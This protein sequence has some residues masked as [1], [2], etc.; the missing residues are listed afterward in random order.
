[1]SLSLN[2]AQMKAIYSSEP[3]LVV[4]APPGSGKTRCMCA[5][6]QEYQALHPTHSITAI[7]YTRKAAVELAERIHCSRVKTGTIHS[8]SLQQLYILGAKY[9]FAVELLEEEEMRRIMQKIAY[10]KNLKFVNI[11]QLYN[12]IVGNIK[13]LDLDENIQKKYEK[14]KALY[15]EYKQDRGLYD[16]T[17]LPQYLLDV[18]EEYDEEI[19]DID[20]LFVD[21]FQDIDEIQ[22]SVFEKVCARKKFYIGDF[23]QCQPAGTKVWLLGHKEKNIEDIQVGDEIVYYDQKGGRCGGRGISGT[24]L[25]KKVT[26]VANREFVN[27]NL[28]TITTENGLTSSYTPGHRTFI[29]INP[30]K[31]KHAVYLMCDSNYRFRV[32]KIPLYYDSPRSPNSWRNKLSAEKCEKIWL[33]KVF[34]TD[35]EARL[36]ETRIS[37]LYQIP[38]TC[39]QVGKVSWTKEDIDYIYEGLDTQTSADRCL[40]DYGLDINY[41][42]LDFS[43][44]WSASTHFAA[45]ATAEI[46][47]SNLM[48]EY[49]SCVVY[50]SSEGNHSN[51]HFETITKVKKTFITEPIQVY[52]LQVE[53]ETYIADGIATHNCIYGF[54]GAVEDV[55][56][57]LSKA[58]FKTYHLDTNYRSKQEIMDAADS[59]RDNCN[60]NQKIADMK[61]LEHSPI[62]CE[63]GN[64]GSIYIIDNNQYCLSMNGSFGSDNAR[65]IVKGLL[66]KPGTMVLCRSNKQVRK[67]QTLGIENC[68]TVHQ[69]KGL[70]YDNVILCDIFVN[71][72][73]ELNV[74]YVGMTRARDE[75]CIIDF[76]AFVGVLANTTI[77]YANNAPKNTLF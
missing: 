24:S 48:P 35:K 14:I 43:I 1:M 60:Y 50:G 62:C 70:E 34:D 38:Q 37:Y 13:T 27:D 71:N 59:F 46:Y 21:E 47:A 33:L 11:Y 44:P 30:I 12:Y 67:L 64:G 65:I 20:A 28:I 32:G 31:D 15:I 58:G 26:A 41:P 73:E 19:Y 61:H 2:P 74:A 55:F 39:W 75:L 16:F 52:S 17:D 36:E 22:F 51:K 6:I 8:W 76:D 42:L 56:N 7:T 68:S 4:V 69:A 10:Q 66:E 23:R 9:G 5:A 40:Q 29:K 3:K 57:R 18:L 49:M 77:N 53:G 25:R 72:E 54:N 63:R 45:N